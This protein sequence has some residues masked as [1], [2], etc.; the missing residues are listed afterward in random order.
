[1]S[2]QL[3][4]GISKM[5]RTMARFSPLI[6][7]A[8]LCGRA[9]ADDAPFPGAKT[10]YHGFDRYDFE[11]DGQKCLVVVPTK[12]AKGKSWIWRA[13]FFDHRPEIDLALVKK[14]FHLV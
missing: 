2:P 5:A 4:P 13:E 10:Q 3:V 12:V 7:L 6:L 11:V 8:L 14:G 1:M 9:D